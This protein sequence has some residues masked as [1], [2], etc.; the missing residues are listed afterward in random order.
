M[1]IKIIKINDLSFKKEKDYGWCCDNR[2]LTMKGVKE[3]YEIMPKLKEIEK[4][5]E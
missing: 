4:L 3:A 5:L 1:K 2:G